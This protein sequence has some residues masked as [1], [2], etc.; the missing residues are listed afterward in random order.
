[1]NPRLERCALK[2]LLS[3]YNVLST[4][5]FDGK[6]RREV[7]TANFFAPLSLLLLL[8]MLVVSVE[9]GGLSAVLV[10]LCCYCFDGCSGAVNC[11]E[12]LVQYCKKQK[13]TALDKTILHR[14]EELGRTGN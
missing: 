10:W 1:M 11:F 8:L 13:M 14:Q 5:F 7:V 9:G 12:I 4:F 6:T 2:K 3:D